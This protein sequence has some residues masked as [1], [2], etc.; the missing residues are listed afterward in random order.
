[1]SVY[2]EVTLSNLRQFLQAYAIGEPLQLQGINDGIENTNYFV[3]TEQGKFVLTLFEA[4]SA[5]ELPYFL[6]L[7]A[8]YAEHQIPCAHPVA[9][10]DGYFLGELNSRPAAL[11]ECLSGE[12]V[13]T[14]TQ[15][16]CEQIGA[17]LGKMHL[18]SLKFKC[19]R[20]N[21]YGPGWRNLVIRK[22]IPHLSK[23]ETQLLKSE[24]HY[25]RERPMSDLP[26]G[27][28]HGDL[29]RDNALFNDYE[30][31]G[32]LDLYDSSDGVFVY[33]LAVTVNDWCTKTNGELDNIKTHSLLAA[34]HYYRPLE[35]NEQNA[36]PTALR[37]SALRFWLSRLLDKY[38]PR[39]GH[40]VQKKNP[41][42]FRQILLLRIAENAK[43]TDLW[44]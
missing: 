13:T 10:I 3:T 25:L 24:Q 38:F 14:P 18:A 12:S 33:D 19:R 34:Y 23:G 44:L 26:T 21:Q 2:T 35:K 9:N 28:I 6:D 1:M 5:Q 15:N 37:S 11:I 7:M 27:V 31:A 36:W 29:F 42:T 8:F 17:V 32:V 4:L 22:L 39:G 41:E 30:L 16:Q 43:L 40:L 20:P